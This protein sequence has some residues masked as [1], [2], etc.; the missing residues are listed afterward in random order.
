[1]VFYRKYFLIYLN[2]LKIFTIKNYLISVQV[3]SKLFNIRE[4]L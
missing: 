1:M 2:I 3:T 4:E